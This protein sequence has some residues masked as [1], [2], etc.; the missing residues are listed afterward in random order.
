MVGG[1]LHCRCNV[2]TVA[3]SAAAAA[4]HPAAA[5]TGACMTAAAAA[6]AAAATPGKPRRAR[7]RAVRL[8]GPAAAATT[9]PPA[10]NAAAAAAA[11]VPAVAAAALARATPAPLPCALVPSHLALGLRVRAEALG[12]Q[13]RAARKGE[14]GQ[15]AAAGWLHGVGLGAEVALV[16]VLRA[17]AVNGAQRRALVGLPVP[18]LGR[19]GLA[20]QC[21]VLPEEAVLRVGRPHLVV[22]TLA[23]LV[24]GQSAEVQRH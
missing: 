15:V 24:L 9:A 6:A 21:D 14:G 23:Q 19:T 11:L 3:G 18:T 5:A 2:L 13:R 20:L 17:R 10:P 4:V 1:G 22:A 7:W 16:V 8:N 12:G